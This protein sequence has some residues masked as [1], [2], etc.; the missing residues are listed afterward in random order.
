MLP[1]FFV[2][3]TVLLLALGGINWFVY[4]RLSHALAL[5]TPWRRALLA[6]LVGGL[7]SMIV[8]RVLGD[9]GGIGPV[10]GVTGA[11]IQLAAIVA[12][13]ILLIERVLDAKLRVARWM[14]GRLSSARVA[15]PVQDAEEGLD[16]RTFL[17]KA[18][19]G[20][21]LALGT[22]SA[23]YASLFGRHDYVIEDV[24]IRLAKLPPTLDGF[25]I[26]QLSDLHLGTFVGEREI[27]AALTLVEQ[28]RPDLI[29]LTGDLLDHDPR[30][31][32]ALGS[33]VERLVERARV[34]AIPGNHDYYA[35][36]DTMVRAIE[37]A[38]G[39]M[40]VNRAVSIGDRGGSIA[41][42]G[43][44]DVWSRRFGRGG[45]PDLD[46]ALTAVAADTPRVLLC[47]NPVFFPE[48]APRVDLQ[49]S[50][51]THGGQFNPGVQPARLV[52]PF[53][54]VAGLYTKGDARLYVNRGFG[55]AGPPARLGATPEVSRI[56]LTV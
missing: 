51:H 10:L 39:E 38:G 19:A 56:I 13:A 28:A 15:S 53:G 2:F 31:A 47:H 26:V 42:V 46:R 35:G 9:T 33:L 54:Y 6:V 24:P 8:G 37:Q 22:G 30:Y 55:T 11:T 4:R 41:L 34:L 25:T 36:V 40:L 18:S 3:F 23:G 43:V 49:L 44:D 50:G 14:F 5:P 7:V 21:A 20:A 52:L 17:A 45:G 12:F 32:G 1:R 29:V 16:R 27:R 48:A